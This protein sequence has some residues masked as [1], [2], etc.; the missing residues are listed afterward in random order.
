M[1]LLRNAYRVLVES[2][3]ERDHQEDLDLGGKK[4]LK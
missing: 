1:Q 2:Q 4:I 3:E